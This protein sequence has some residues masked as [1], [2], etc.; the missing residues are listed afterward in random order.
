MVYFKKS[1]KVDYVN[2][3][4]KSPTPIG[5]AVFVGLRAFDP[6][7]QYSI[8]A[9]GIGTSLLYH[10][11]LTALPPGIPAHTGIF[12]ID[13][14]QL[15]PYRLII[16]GMA[17][18]SAVKHCI[19]ATTISGEGMY[20]PSAITV[21]AFN[22]A[23]NSLNT[24]LFICE[25]TSASTSSNA[26]FPQ[27]PLIVGGTMYTVGILTELIAEVQRK[28][29][30]S[31]PKNQ[32]K[33][34]TGGLWNLAR[35]INYGAFTVWR[36][37]YAIASAGWTWGALTGAFFFFDFATRGIPVLDDYCTKRYGQD[38]ANFKVKVPSSLLPGI[39]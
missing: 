14:L 27:L 20:I 15:S 5:R 16:L 34:Y 38:W 6:F 3:Y 28:R 37:G 36:A 29:F 12:F 23:F 35:H 26:R 25:Q 33:P 18:G 32:G 31:E 21:G 4:D 19:W 17:L 13:G 8:L 2:R 39:Y 24:C 1:K 9:Q 22:L 30:K 10:V 11:G 7:L